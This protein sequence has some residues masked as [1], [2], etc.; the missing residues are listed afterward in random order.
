MRKIS[1]FIVCAALT[2]TM[3]SCTQDLTKD[4]LVEVNDGSNIIY[5]KIDN[6]H[7]ERA[8]LDN[9]LKMSWIAGDTV[10]VMGSGRFCGYGFNGNTG[11]NF[12]S[13]TEIPTL[14]HYNNIETHKDNINNVKW[15]NYD[16]QV[17]AICPYGGY[18][19][20]GSRIYLYSTKRTLSNQHYTPN[21]SDPA[22][23]QV[24]SASDDG[25]N[26]KFINMLGYLRLAI[27]GEKVVKSITL[28]DRA[29]NTIGG[30]YYFEPD[31]PELTT[32]VEGSESSTITLDCGEGVQ[33]SATPTNFFFAMLPVVMSK[34]CSVQINFTDGSKL[35]QS[36]T[37]EI[38][39]R[40]NAMRPMAV[41]NTSDITYYTLGITYDSA[42]V[43]LPEFIGTTALSGYVDWGDG[44]SS[45][46]QLVTSYDYTDNTSSH[47]ATIK[48]NNVEKIRFNGCY[49]ISEIDLSNF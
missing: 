28:S 33:L 18:L 45:I 43:V 16:N 10:F 11:D 20:N 12:G 21:G 6:N 48:V 2:G 34:G 25:V 15:S 1:N 13:F 37:N 44:N 22:M 7:D 14:N 38:E 31:T 9:N 40:R 29:G 17:F 24:F 36:T 27:T 26:F 49:G 39:I 41:I 3:F 42:S 30:R 23:S 32:W 19:R 47:R 35:V 8:Q 46:L 4:I 5:A